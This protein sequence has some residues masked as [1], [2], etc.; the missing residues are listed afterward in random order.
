MSF[1]AEEGHSIMNPNCKMPPRRFYTL[2]SSTENLGMVIGNQINYI[3]IYTKLNNA[4]KSAKTYPGAEI[5]C[6]HILELIRLCLNRKTE[7]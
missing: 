4:V 5:Y 7:K 6:V 3:L 1:C 2:K